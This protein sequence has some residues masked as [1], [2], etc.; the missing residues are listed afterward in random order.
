V[1]KPAWGSREVTRED[2]AT[3]V[4]RD[5]IESSSRVRIT[6]GMLRHLGKPRRV[7]HR[8]ASL[9]PARSSPRL[10]SLLDPTPLRLGCEL[11]AVVA[12]L[13]L[14]AWVVWVLLA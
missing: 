14:V 11:G 9:R 10:G 4:K 6:P 1:V 8:P 7:I 2:R 5:L 13:A 3:A 12:V